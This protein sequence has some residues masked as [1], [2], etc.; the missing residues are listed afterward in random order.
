MTVEYI[1]HPYADLWPLLPDNE[2]QALADDIRIHGL[3]EPIW[4]HPDGRIVD[5]RNRYRACAL[6]GIEPATRTYKGTEEGLLAFLISLNMARRHM[7]ESQRSMVT[8][9]IA[10]LPRGA[11]Q[12]SSIELPSQAEAAALM[13]VSL[14]S[15][16]RAAK[17]QNEAVP[18]LQ[19]A[20]ESGRVSVSAAAGL[21][22][23]P[24]EEQRRVAEASKSDSYK[25]T[26]AAIAEARARIDTDSRLM[27]AHV[28]NN[29]GENEWYTPIDY[30]K[31]AH[32]VMGAIDLDPAS[33]STA[34]E[35]V[36]AER[37]YTARDDGL[38]QSWSGRVWMNPPYAQP[39]IEQFCT[40]L[41][42]EYASGD[43]EQATVLVNNGTE[44]AWFQTLAG[45]A[46]AMC[47]PRGRVKFW[48]PNRVAMPL[49]GQTVIYLGSH[50]EA[51]RREFQPFGFVVV[52]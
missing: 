46:T 40:R 5:G 11:N 52:L 13:N 38:K 34:N 39:L 21:T 43:V 16:K 28:G 1:V 47:F 12:H 24:A 9:K 19:E 20:V 22:Q 15:V 31:A 17:V 29:S 6:A 36:G 32:A 37:F 33:S 23:A 26:Q 45:E 49:Q 48:H 2:L 10:R 18:E 30:I 8:A 4:L 50:L 35:T 25:E 42:Q 7:D 41:A 51:F 14:A 27:G 3:R 44:T